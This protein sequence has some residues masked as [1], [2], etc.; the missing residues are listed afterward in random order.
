MK[1]SYDFDY[2]VIGSGFG[3]SVSACRLSEKGY[4]VAVLEMGKRWKPRDFPKTNWNLKRYFWAPLIR[5][6]GFFRLSLFRHAWV[7][8]GVGVG[9]GSLVYANV[10]L[11]PKPSVWQDPAWKELDDWESVMPPFYQK[12]RTMLGSETN[13]HLGPADRMLKEAA[14]SE[15]LG[16]SFAPTP[17]GVY[18]GKPGVTVSDPYFGGLGPE[19]T[20]CQFCGG[21]MVGCRHGA[22]NSLDFNYLYFAEKQGVQ[23]FPETEVFDVK[24]LDGKSDGTRGYRISCRESIRNGPRVEVSF[25]CRGVV[26]SAGV[27]GTLPLL[28]K[29]RNSGSLPKLS[30]KLGDGARTNSESLI[31]IRCDESPDDLSEGVAI[32]SGFTLDDETQIEAV[33]YPKG[34]DVMG[35]TAT[36][37]THS[38]PGW[39][40]IVAWLLEVVLHPLEF[41]KTLRIFGWAEKSIILL[42]MQ[43]CDTSFRM[44]LKRC[45]WNPLRQ[46]LQS[47]GKRVPPFIE[48]ANQFAEKMARRF[49]G[50]PMTALTE[51]FF[52]V[53]TTAHI[54][55]GSIMGKDSSEGVIDSRNQVFHYHNL[56]V[57][58]GSMIGA[59]L[60]VNPSLTI[61]ALTERAMSHIP[62]RSDHPDFQ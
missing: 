50:K 61:T 12:A 44:R 41:L 24:P 29:L 21:C 40:R 57:C 42:V 51:I 22:K 14:D 1:E 4:R 37:M 53:P 10:L 36:L 7:L 47:E 48:P 15:K 34:S 62:K 55:G 3:G 23:V 38:L 58:D 32:G 13:P 8:S 59:N 9:G 60:G 20:G 52:N 18:F 6:F 17:V 43:T 25:Q 56:Y 5:W 45:W 19:R 33:R 35:L 28:L 16:D 49:R 31:G 30:P 27:L 39:R 26:F 2:I 11:E 46:S 54:L